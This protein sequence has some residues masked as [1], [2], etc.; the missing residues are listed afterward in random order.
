[1]GYKIQISKDDKVLGY[2]HKGKV[3][4]TPTFYANSY[5]AIKARDSFVAKTEG[6]L[7]CKILLWQSNKE[8]EM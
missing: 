2:L 4:L 3:S 5:T 7:T 1:V 8:I 6:R